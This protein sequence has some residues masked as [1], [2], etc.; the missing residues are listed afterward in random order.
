MR[1]SVARLIHDARAAAGLTQAE[2]ARRAGTSQPAIA[3]YERGASSPSVLT[4]ERILAA[5]G[6]RLALTAT[7]SLTAHDASS[8]RMRKLRAHRREILALARAHGM[9]DVRIFGSVVHGRDTPTSDIDLVVD[10]VF[11][12][13]G[14]FP[15]LD[16]RDAVAE[17]L[18]ERVDVVAAPILTPEV[19]AQVEREG[20]P[21]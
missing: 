10:P 17:L 4:L 9:R 12:R 5:A 14:L 16:F 21:L 7:P 8:A 18:N 3:R 19:A 15:M 6:Q 2:L 20:I 13:H 11:G 1:M